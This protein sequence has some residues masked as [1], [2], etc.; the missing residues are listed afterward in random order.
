MVDFLKALGYVFLFVGMIAVAIT[1][2]ENASF[3]GFGDDDA[4]DDSTGVVLTET[5]PARVDLRNVR[6]SPTFAVST[7]SSVSELMNNM[8]VE[9]LYFFESPDVEP[10]D[11]NARVYRTAFPR[12]TTRGVWWDLTFSHPR[13]TGL[14]TG[15]L[16]SL[17][18]GPNGFRE[19]RVMEFSAWPNT[20]ETKVIGGHGFDEPGRLDR[21]RYTVTLYMSRTPLAIG[22]F[23]I[24]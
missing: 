22:Q 17:I 11:P 16:L 8:Y 6:E 2:S 21:G 18:V 3:L 1:L 14:L 12:A 15:E 7:V 19:P 10:V 9:S 20:T 5:G 13:T 24:E 4:A 23:D